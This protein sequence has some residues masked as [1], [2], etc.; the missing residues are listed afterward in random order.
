MVSSIAMQY[1]EIITL[2]PHFL[3]VS[4]PARTI[5]QHEKLNPSALGYLLNLKFPDLWNDVQENNPPFHEP[6]GVHRL[7]GLVTG[8]VLFGRSRHGTR[9]LH[10]LFSKRLIEKRYI[11]LLRSSRAI[12]QSGTMETEGRTTVYKVLQEVPTMK[13]VTLVELRT[14][15][16]RN[17]QLRI[18]VAECL[19]APVLYD[20]RYA[21]TPFL[22]DP[23]PQTEDEG[24]ALHCA[25][26]S[27]TFGLQ[28]HTVACN[29]PR[30][31]IWQKMRELGVNVD[32]VS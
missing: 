9:C 19:A 10:K 30:Y 7:D 14:K 26:M 17:H 5:C 1:L 20:T 23:W 8:C 21:T 12:P 28:R 15:E 3:C 31:G 4:K 11:A 32:D 29:P 16:G 18:H 6:R 24:I 13:G 22:P 25:S 2:T 27:F